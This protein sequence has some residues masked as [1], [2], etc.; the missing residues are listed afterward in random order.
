MSLRDYCLIMIFCF[1]FLAT[2]IWYHKTNSF[3]EEYYA[4]NA[5]PSAK[6]IDRCRA[7]LEQLEKG[8]TIV[9]KKIPKLNNKD[10]LRFEIPEDET[11]NYE[12]IWGEENITIDKKS[13]HVFFPEGS[14]KPSAKPRGWAGFIYAA[15]E[16][17]GKKHALLSYTLWF[18]DNF[19]FVKGGKLPGFCSG[20]C[21][22][23]WAETDNGF[24]TRFMWRANGDLEVYGYLPN[25]S[26]SMGQSIGRGMFRFKPGQYYDVAQEIVLNTL[27]ENDGILRVYV[28]D[29]MVYEKT[30]MMYQKEIPLSVD[31]ILF[32]TFF[33][34]WDTSWATPVDTSITFEDFKIEWN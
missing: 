33:G 19:D 3:S 26:T 8:E 5:A 20:D 12:S 15:D 7:L 32:S 4:L 21:P 1:I 18:A 22:R 6:K 27:W 25:K 14:Y 24:S 34:G 10:S 2:G 30:D 23:G 28:D 31:K 11:A 9:E 16:L 29:I 17:S 13:L